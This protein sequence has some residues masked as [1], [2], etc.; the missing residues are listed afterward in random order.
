MMASGTPLPKVTPEQESRYLLVVRGSGQQ[1]IELKGATL[2]IG[3]RAGRDIVFPDAHVSREHARI[4]FGGGGYYVVD[5]QSTHGTFVNG[6]RVERR[7]LKPGDRIEFGAPG[8]CCVLFHCEQPAEEKSRARQFL[9]QVAARPTAGASE[10]ETLRMF[11]EAAHALNTSGVLTDVLVTLIDSA[12]R[13]TRAERGF[14]FLC[15]RR[16]ELELAQGRD[17]RGLVLTEAKGISRSVL[18]EATSTASEFLVT[19]TEDEA[20]LAGRQSIVA[21][22]LRTIVCIPLRRSQFRKGENQHLETH[23]SINGVLYLDSH[24]IAGK[25]SSVSHD[26]LRMLATE[27][28]S[29]VENAQLVKAEQDALAYERELAIASTIQQR[30]MVV[31]LPH[32]PFASIEAR[33][34]SCKEVG[35]DFFDVIRLAD[36]L[37]L[38]LADVSGKGMSAALLASIIQGMVYPQLV[39]GIPLVKIAEI[40]NRFIY[41][42]V[43]GQKYATLV[44]AKLDPFGTLEYINC[45]HIRPVL[46]SGDTVTRPSNSNL[47]V[48]LVLPATFEGEVVKLHKGDEL[49][50]I[51]DGIIEAEDAAGEFFGDE[52][53]EQAVA[54]GCSLEAVFGAVDRFRGCTPLNDDCS[55]L[56][57]VYRG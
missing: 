35:G 41:E 14:V 33:N 57:L 34:I 11:L 36:S 45:G 52:R 8:E 50:V 3:R 1:R 46:V 47:P 29:L 38:V 15:D 17:N 43:F 26:L 51:S 10:L 37:A 7:L 44:L 13:L 16:G 49:L 55:V 30:L 53:L 42:K 25:L 6:E 9:T 21:H 27:A 39:Q 18:R 40:A 54:Q 28:A 32:V 48:G 56:K 23:G 12:L 24:L 4:E 5:Q 31:N 19:G 20:K 2:T 22:D